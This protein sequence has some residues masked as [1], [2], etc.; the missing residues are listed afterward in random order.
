MPA[1]DGSSLPAL[2][3]HAARRGSP[4]CR[5]RR[6]DWLARGLGVASLALGVPPIARPGQVT[7]ALGIADEPR[8]RSAAQLVGVRE[9]VVAAGLLLGRGRAGWLWARVAGDAIDVALLSRALRNHQGAGRQRTVAATA[10][11]LGITAIDCYAAIT[12]SGEGFTVHMTSS[13]TISRQPQDI[14]EY[15]RQLDNLPTFM[16]HLEEVRLTE[17]GRS[18][19]RASAPF[20]RSVEWDAE[21]TEDVPGQRISWRS[22]EG[23]DIQ[24][25]GTVKFTAAPGGRGTEVH[26][27]LEYS[28]PAGKLGEAVARYFGEDPRQQ[29][30]DDLRRFKQVIETGE[31]VRSD[32]APGGKRARK[33]FPQHPARPL[34]ADELAEEVSV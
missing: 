24:N 9:L 15:W 25:Q 22:T 12:R 10:A 33:E 14:Y 20:G 5:R 31:V 2:S 28:L 29:L 26:V 6:Q 4:D 16:A 30:D 19:W 18:H 32:G 34:T 11:V 8:H 1:S 21:T 17:E 27:E 7:E 23:A 3:S 13:T